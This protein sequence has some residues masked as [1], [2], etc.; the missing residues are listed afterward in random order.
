M[1]DI[2]SLLTVYV[3]KPQ[4]VLRCLDAP[5]HQARLASRI[6]ALFSKI[7]AWF[8]KGKKWVTQCDQDPAH[9]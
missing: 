1:S 4:T 6:S 3:A 5:D 7:S 8:K 2:K 9:V